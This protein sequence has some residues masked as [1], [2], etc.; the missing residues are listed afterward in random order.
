M[1]RKK[2]FPVLILGVLVLQ[3]CSTDP[4]MRSNTLSGDAVFASAKLP[5]FTARYNA[6][7]Q[8]YGTSGVSPAH[9]SDQIYPGS[10]ISI[11][12]KTNISGTTSGHD[13][14][15]GIIQDGDGFQLNFENAD[16]A[17]VCK[18]ILGDVL[19][20]NYT[21]DQRINGQITL[22]SAHP[23]AKSNL[24]KVL[25]TALKAVNVSILKENALLRVVPFSEG[26]G[27]ART[28]FGTA[29]EGFGTTVIPVKFVSVQ[30]VARI[31]QSF[32]TAQGA[33]KADPGTNTIIVQ[34]TEQER[35]AAMDA[36]NAVD[37]NLLRSQSVGLFP[38]ANSAPDSIIVELSKILNTGEGGIGQNEAQFQPMSRMNAVLVIAR[39]NEVLETVR[40]WI[41]RLDTND[42]A[43]VGVKIYRL[44]YAQAKTVAS[45]LG[46]VLAGRSSPAGNSDQASLQPSSTGSSNLFES[47]ATASNGKPSGSNASPTSNTRNS[48]SSTNT[49]DQSGQSSSDQHSSSGQ[50]SGQGSLS[51]VRITPDITNNSLLVMAGPSDYRI[52]EAAIRQLD[53]P[54]VQVAIEATIAEVTLT[55]ELQYG[56]QAYLSNQ[57]VGIGSHSS[58][59]INLTQSATSAAISAVVPGANLILGPQSSPRVVLNALH[60]LTAVKVLSAP[61]LVVLDNQSAALQVGD[62]VAIK[63]QS[64]ESTDSSTAPVINSI[65][66]KDT[67]I[68]LKVQPHIHANG[69]VNLDVQQEISSVVS[70][71]GGSDGL[72]PTISQ[73]KVNSSIAVS[74]GQ[75]VLLAGMISQQT[76]D[77]NN[78]LPNPTTWKWIDDVFGSHDKQSTRTELIIFIKPQIMRDQADAQA[79]SEE[80]SDRMS[81]M[82]PAVPPTKAGVVY[83]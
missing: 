62:Q 75:T 57:N 61:S 21:I 23:V 70:N 54:P 78:G 4:S 28:E 60:S 69:I 2:A 33:I 37:T 64:S 51:N 20:Q 74:S 71:T 13:L 19:Q 11:A 56:V 5:D 59:T 43:A 24:I 42:V 40:N 18:T 41:H 81:A 16:V 36:A 25:E 22:S 55:D 76:N 34:G 14:G 77:T 17:A 47:P 80:F 63:T 83:K 82:L 44:K 79:V 15:Q 67:G 12:D 45:L 39:N 27:A 72:T 1:Y 53:R 10:S 68:I 52:V 3:A 48:Q 31:L 49:I 29:S 50:S 8:P 65:T 6:N 73:R 32:A 26:V 46:D 30:T 9:Q 35:R 7:P 38:L 58:A 66:Y